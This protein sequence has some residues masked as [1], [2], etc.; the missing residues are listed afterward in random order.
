MKERKFEQIL[1]R[2]LQEAIRTGDT[3]AALRRYP[4][5]ADGL[6]PLLEVALAT[7]RAYADVPAP[8]GRLEA[9]RRRLLET[10]V[11]Q[12]ERTQAHPI[13]KQ[14]KET[15]PKMKLVLA[16]RLI[17]AALAAV[18]GVATIG[19]GATLAAADSLPGEMLYPVKLAGEDLRVSLAS[20]PE[21][22][23]S[24]ALQ[25]SDERTTEIQALV[26]QGLPVPDTVVARME[27][28][29]VQ[30]MNQAAW[31][32]EDEMPGLLKRIAQRTQTQAQTLEQV[33]A[34]AQEQN[35]F[36][37]ENAWR[38]CQQAQEDAT[39]GL[40][41]PQAFRSRYQNRHSMPDDVTPP[42]P[43]TRE[44]QDGEQGAGPQGPAGPQ[45][46]GMPTPPDAEQD[47]EQD[48]DRDRDREDDPQQDQDRDRDREDEPQ[49][50]QDRDRDRDQQDD[51]QQDQDRNRDQDPQDDPAQ[52]QDRDQDRDRAN[53]P[54]QDQ[55]R[56]EN[57]N[58]QQDPGQ[59]PQ[60][61]QQQDQQQ[62]E[63]NESENGDSS[64]DPTPSSQGD[65][66][67]GK[68]NG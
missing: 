29:I 47:G 23:V 55:D 8:P 26:E 44:P 10:A 15:K 27:R 2:C 20:T 5:H 32:S 17:G 43:P 40:Q 61:D 51:P 38:I 25:F 1:E 56:E 14:R 53:D 34:E 28:H 57:Q 67:N 66:G 42:E 59:E 48:R 50:D 16:T 52:N 9:G 65:N 21:D 18:I 39:T 60:Q 62:D 19:G 58:R 33:Q 31:A 64:D 41:D 45:S 11:R 36:Q 30:A 4:Q 63:Q 3:E 7:H 13:L 37:I 6:R 35:Q 49:Q 22:E 12:R 24:L 46:D 68:G 54:D